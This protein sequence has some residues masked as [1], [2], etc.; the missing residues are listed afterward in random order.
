MD[1]CHLKFSYHIFK[2][3]SVTSR[4]LTRCLPLAIC[5]TKRTIRGFSGTKKPIIPRAPRTVT[6]GKPGN[7]EWKGTARRVAEMVLVVP[8]VTRMLVEYSS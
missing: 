6:N 4:N 5:R 1:L 3:K 7:A 2:R 8:A